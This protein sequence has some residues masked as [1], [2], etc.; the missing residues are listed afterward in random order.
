[1]ERR[2]DWAWVGVLAGWRRAPSAW[3]SWALAM[4]GC[5]GRGVG[6]GDDDGDGE[7]LGGGHLCVVLSCLSRLSGPVG[8]T[9]TVC[10]V[11]TP[12]IRSQTHTRTPS[13]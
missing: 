1:M 3:Q 10:T 4:I 2:G 5:S 8:F 7:P 6:G 12:L 13:K 11:F 9:V